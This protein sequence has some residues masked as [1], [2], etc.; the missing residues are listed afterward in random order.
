LKRIKHLLFDLDGTLTDPKEGITK[1]IEY[2]LNK[3]DITVEHLDQLIPYIGPPLF[4]S[5]I[6]LNAFNEENAHL[7]VGYYRER[8]RELGIFENKVIPGIPELLE[9]LS[10]QGYLMYVATSKPTV[11]AEQ[12]VEHYQLGTYF[13]HI[14]GSHLDGTRSRKQEVIEYVLTHNTIS[15]EQALMIGDRE[16]DIFGA[17][18]CGVKSVG[19]TFGYGSELE[20]RDAGADYI[21]HQVKDF[22]KLITTF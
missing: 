12:I 22:E 5:F 18:A 7:A 14:G 15:S 17:K 10:N 19:V 2:A 8:Y 20:L 21:V 9:K 4:D 1:S 6:Q 16:H 3:F 11:F 13:Q